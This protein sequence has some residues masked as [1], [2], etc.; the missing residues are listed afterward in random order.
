[1]PK[2]FIISLGGTG[3]R[4][5]EKLTYLMAAGSAID[6]VLEGVSLK[7]WDFVPMIVDFDKNNPDFTSCNQLLEE[8]YLVHKK[9]QAHNATNSNNSF[10][11]YNILKLNDLNEHMISNGFV[12][13]IQERKQHL[14]DIIGYTYL[15]TKNDLQEI[16]QLTDLLFDDEELQMPLDKGFQ[17]K[18]NIAPFALEQL[19]H[20]QDFQLLTK[21]LSSEDRVFI[22]GSSFGGMASTALPRFLN[23]LRFGKNTVNKTSNNQIKIGVLLTNPYF[24][25]TKIRTKSS[26]RVNSNDFIGKTKA[27]LKYFEYNIQEANALYSI[28]DDS[29]DWAS[30]DH[31]QDKKVT[32]NKAQPLE[33]FGALSLFHFLNQND[34]QL[35]INHTRFFRYCVKIEGNKKIYFKHFDAHQPSSRWIKLPLTLF[36]IASI[37]MIWG[38][39]YLNKYELFPKADLVTKKNNFF[40]GSK[41]DDSFYRGD[42][43]KAVESFMEKFL[44]FVQELETTNDPVFSPFETNLGKKLLTEGFPPINDLIRESPISKF[45][46][47]DEVMAT[48]SKS[49]AITVVNLMNHMVQAATD[50]SQRLNRNEYKP[51]RMLEFL[52]QGIYSFLDK[53]EHEFVTINK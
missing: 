24:N 21:I 44:E 2:C 43:F 46:L 22:L 47:M 33:L 9:A 1:M 52:H 30:F 38:R 32:K 45:K 31:Y 20:H 19:V 51:L 34:T 3:I 53:Y 42:F 35:P 29:K 10:F 26:I 50:V 12:V 48:T 39:R 49:Q 25:L 18:S 15:Y 5:L 37:L 28:G 27:A 4:I 13:N 41:T 14:A 8:Y 6:D 16:Q 11:R 7:E 36:Y 40:L 23:I 17:G